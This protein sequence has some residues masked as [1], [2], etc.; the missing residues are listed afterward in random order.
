MNENKNKI[1]EMKTRLKSAK[2]M[3]KANDLVILS[4]K[5]ITSMFVKGLSADQ[6]QELQNFFS[7]TKEQKINQPDWS[8]ND[9]LLQTLQTIYEL[10]F[11]EGALKESDR[12][13]N[14]LKKHEKLIAKLTNDVSELLD[15]GT[16]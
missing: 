5:F 9:Y 8:N 6:K 7:E 16:K 1:I 15:N 11:E 4:S 12:L 10:G 14:L 3:I 2:Q 13:T